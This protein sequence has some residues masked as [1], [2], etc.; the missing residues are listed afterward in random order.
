M[1]RV[2]VTAK[3]KY[4]RLA[5]KILIVAKIVEARFRYVLVVEL[6]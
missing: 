5:S 6:V 1:L 2:H 4:N 3:N